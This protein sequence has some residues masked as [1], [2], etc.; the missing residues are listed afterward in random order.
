[1][2]PNY[3]HLLEKLEDKFCNLIVLHARNAN[4]I[5]YQKSY[6]EALKKARTIQKVVAF[7]PLS[8]FQDIT[9]Y[10]YIKLLINFYN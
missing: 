10:E 3:A 7:F 2:T 9:V 8:I 4:Q 5:F 6:T 1:M